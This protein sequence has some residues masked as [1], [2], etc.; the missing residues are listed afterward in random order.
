MVFYEVDGMGHNDFTSNTED[1]NS[2][3]TIWKFFKQYTLDSPCDTTLKWRPNIEA[4]EYAP[5]RHGWKMDAGTT[6][7]LFGNY[8]K[9]DAN[10]NVYHSLQLVD[11]KYKLCFHIKGVSGTKA[12]VKLVKET[13]TKKEIVNATVTENGDVTLPFTVTGGW[14]E[15][16]LGIFRRSKTDQMKVTKLA[17]YSVSDEEW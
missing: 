2:S 1:G 7:Y 17:I 4:E 3:L 11:G 13:G 8:Q 14:G 16:Q 5:T 9:T 15:Y 10:Q 6:A 12:I